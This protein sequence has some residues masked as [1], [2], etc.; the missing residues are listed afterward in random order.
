ML[1][2]RKFEKVAGHYQGSLKTSPRGLELRHPRSSLPFQGFLTPKH[3]TEVMLHLYLQGCMLR[4]DGH[5]QYRGLKSH[6]NSQTILLYARY[7][8]LH[9][10]YF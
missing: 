5:N 10:R 4:D 9:F 1:A 2:L 7:Y 3:V 6:K 8:S